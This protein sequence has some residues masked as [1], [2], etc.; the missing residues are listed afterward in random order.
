MKLHYSQTLTAVCNSVILFYYLMK[1]HYSQTVLIV[2][3]SFVEFYYLMKLHYSQT[4]Y[5]K[6]KYNSYVLLP[7][8]ITLFSNFFSAVINADCVLL[9]YE[10][11]LFS[12][13]VPI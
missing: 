1:L 9:P 3:L 12:N 8:E 13:S 2:L 6:E 5:L 11:T 10:I 7:Y 4:K